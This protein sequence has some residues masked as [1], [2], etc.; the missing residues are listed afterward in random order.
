MAQGD[1]CLEKDALEGIRTDVPEGIRIDVPEGAAYILR[2]LKNNGFEGFVVGGCVRDSLIDRNP[3]DW[4]ITSNAKPEQIKELFRRTVDTGIEHGTVTVLIGDDAYEVT[5]YRTDGEYTDHRHPKEVIFTPSLEED[6]ARRDFTINAMAYNEDRHL[7]DLYGGIKDL[8]GKVIKCVGNPWDRFDEDALRMLRAIRFSG[9]LEYKLDDELRV[10]IKKLSKTITFVSAERIRQELS[11]LIVSKGA[12][13]ILELHNTGLGSYVLPELEAMLDTKQNNKHHCYDVGNHSLKALQ[14][15]YKIWQEKCE[16]PEDYFDYIEQDKEEIFSDK[17][18]TA[19]FYACLFHDIG[20]PATKTTDEDGVDHFY[21]H[22]GVGKDMV[23]IVLRRLKF[24]NETIKMVTLLV[25]NHE[26]RHEGGKKGMRK[27][28]NRMGKYMPYLFWLQ[29]SDILAQSDYKR[30]DKLH[31]LSNAKSMYGEIVRDKDPIFTGDLVIDG[32]DLIDMGMR[33]GPGIG[34]VLS[35]LL[36]LVW[37][38]PEYNQ[39]DILLK[40]AEVIACSIM[41]EKQ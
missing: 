36:D 38:N 12:D 35:K 19:L 21:G 9:Q 10:A 8:R 20:K 7:V 27:L 2:T 39:R 11:K 37:K 34:K 1:D 5:T 13:K 32:G 23:R 26:N 3:M 16:N 31:N 25:E 41:A 24:D 29:E 17:M 28:M 40:K 22:A 14:N 30:E 18:K 33:K 15:I 6:L 4:D